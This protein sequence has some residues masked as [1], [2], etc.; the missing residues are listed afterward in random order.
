MISYDRFKQVCLPLKLHFYKQ[1]ILANPNV[2]NNFPFSSTMNIC[3]AAMLESTIQH[4]PSELRNQFCYPP[5][6]FLLTFLSTTH[7]PSY[8]RNS[9]RKTDRQTCAKTY[10]M[11]KIRRITLLLSQ[12]A[13]SSYMYLKILLSQTL[14][15]TSQDHFVRT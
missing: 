15:W 11:L 10:D 3:L 7:S 1:V 12:C 6:T 2:W 8:Q 9:A 4:Y 5:S 14:A 13:R